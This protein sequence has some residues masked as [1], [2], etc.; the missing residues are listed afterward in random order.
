MRRPA[1]VAR[2]PRR[3]RRRQR[4]AHDRPRVACV[5]AAGV[6]DV[7]RG[8]ETQ[9]LVRWRRP[10]QRRRDAIDRAARNPSSGSIVAAARSRRSRPSERRALPVSGTT[11]FRPDDAPAPTPART[12]RWPLARIAR[13]L[14]AG[15]ATA[16]AA[17]SVR[18]AHAA[19]VGNLAAAA[20]PT[21]CPGC[22]SQRNSRGAL[23]R[24][25]RC[26]RGAPTLV[27]AAALSARY[28]RA[29][30]QAGTVS[31][32]VRPTPR[33][34]GSGRSRAGQSRSLG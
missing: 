5:D 6:P 22:S 2:S 23:G 24:A 29:L 10:R 18:H 9:I 8:E 27:G 14:A 7:M 17:R 30:A 15:A 31:V 1:A 32:A 28:A 13:G 34:A 12:A 11:A 26:R 3:S 16:I 25:T 21:T 20:T 4:R 19:L 33:R